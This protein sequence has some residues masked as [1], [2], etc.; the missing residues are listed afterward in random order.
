MGTALLTLLELLV[1]AAIVLGFVYEKKLIAFEDK[2]ALAV[3]KLLLKRGYGRNFRV[4]KS[5]RIGR[6]A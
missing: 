5:A 6:C 3:K 1:A 4:E 2:I